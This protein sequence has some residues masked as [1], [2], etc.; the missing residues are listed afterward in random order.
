LTHD[1]LA[2]DSLPFFGCGQNNRYT[3]CANDPVNLVDAGGHMCVISVNADSFSGMV[4]RA[5][6]DPRT[7]AV[8]LLLTDQILG[9]QDML[10]RGLVVACVAAKARALKEQIKDLESQIAGLERLYEQAL[11]EGASARAEELLAAIQR[12]YI[13]ISAIEDQINRLFE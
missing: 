11:A 8:G 2:I 6:K 12:L 4:A 5:I 10:L 1:P 13:A 3:F 9:I 7:I